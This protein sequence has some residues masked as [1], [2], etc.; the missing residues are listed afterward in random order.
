MI[1]K[2]QGRFLGS[3]P[4]YIGKSY[5]RLLKKEYICPQNQTLSSEY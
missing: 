5:R 2:G 3:V 1:D 4:F